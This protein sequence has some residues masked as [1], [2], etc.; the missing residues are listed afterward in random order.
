MTFDIS[1]PFNSTLM[2]CSVLSRKCL[3]WS[4]SLTIL[5]FIRSKLMSLSSNSAFMFP[6]RGDKSSSGSGERRSSAAITRDKSVTLHNGADNAE[7]RHDPGKEASTVADGNGSER[8]AAVRYWNDVII[9]SLAQLYELPRWCM[10]RMRT[11][12]DRPSMVP[13]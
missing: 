9:V 1:W 7:R 4:F 12:G 10:R 3:L 13:R 5:L 6:C 2:L 8:V 11:S